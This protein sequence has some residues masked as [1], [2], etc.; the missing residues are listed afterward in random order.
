MARRC[1]ALPEV[2]QV[3]PIFEQEPEDEAR[4]GLGCTPLA[5]VRALFGGMSR[6]RHQLQ[7]SLGK[8]SLLD[9]LGTAAVRKTRF[10]SSGYRSRE[11]PSCRRAKPCEATRSLLG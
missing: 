4:A 8:T 2:Q 6:F 1:P 9:V 7:R 10:L 3:R 11:H 5:A